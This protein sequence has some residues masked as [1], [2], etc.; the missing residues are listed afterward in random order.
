MFTASHRT[1]HMCMCVCLFLHILFVCS[2]EYFFNLQ[3]QSEMAETKWLLKK[4]KKNS[5]VLSLFLYRDLKCVW[6]RA[7]QCVVPSHTKQFTNWDVETKRGLLEEEMKRK[8][9]TQVSLTSWT[10]IHWKLSPAYVCVGGVITT[11]VCVWV[12]EGLDTVWGHCLGIHGLQSCIAHYEDDDDNSFCAWED[13]VKDFNH[14][15]DCEACWWLNS[16]VFAFQ[17]DFYSTLC[18]LTL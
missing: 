18:T 4:K 5:D 17:A 13:C 12:F 10:V 9:D 7:F 6:V 1:L 8:E 2:S 3:Q 11:C 15:A 14:A 16:K